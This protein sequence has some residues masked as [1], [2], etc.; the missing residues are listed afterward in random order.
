MMSGTELHQVSGAKWN[1]VQEL[2]DC[3]LSGV[4]I[5]GFVSV[6]RSSMVTNHSLFF[7]IA[8]DRG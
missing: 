7:F 6:I 4:A 5:D 3:A 8:V 1:L 2:D